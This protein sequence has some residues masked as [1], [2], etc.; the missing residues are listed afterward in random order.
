MYLETCTRLKMKA[1][2]QSPDFKDLEDFNKRHEK[3]L[4]YVKESKE[5]LISMLGVPENVIG[6][7]PRSENLVASEEFYH[8]FVEGKNALFAFV[9]TCF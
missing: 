7:T 6:A 2:S 9:S 1:V 8:S 5:I 3:S 4:A